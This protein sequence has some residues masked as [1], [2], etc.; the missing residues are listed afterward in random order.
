MKVWLYVVVAT[1]LSFGTALAADTAIV[2]KDLAFSKTAITVAVGDKVMWGSAD[3]VNHNIHIKG[4]G[5][6]VDL[7]VQKNSEVIS[8]V[9][10]KKGEY[11]VQC[12]IHPR[13]KMT[14]TV[15]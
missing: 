5:E 15:Q 14:V 11:V 3:T 13:M 10:N 8:H 2:Q 6:D 7:G 4:E 12:A 9:F 1:F